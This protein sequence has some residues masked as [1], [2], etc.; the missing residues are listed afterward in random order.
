MT[1]KKQARTTDKQHCMEFSAIS[2]QLKT[3]LSLNLQFRLIAHGI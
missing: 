2:F 3:R 1:E